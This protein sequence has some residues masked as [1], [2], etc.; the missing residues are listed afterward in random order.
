M[1]LNLIMNYHVPQ[2][3][4]KTKY[5]SPNV[6]QTCIK[7]MP[8]DKISKFHI[9]E[10]ASPE[11]Q[12]SG[13]AFDPCQVLMQASANSPWGNLFWYTYFTSAGKFWQVLSIFQYTNW[14]IYEEEPWLY[15]WGIIRSTRSRHLL[16]LIEHED[17][18]DWEHFPHYG[19][20]FKGTTHQSER[21]SFQLERA[22]LYHHRK[23]IGT[24]L[25][26]CG[27]FLSSP[28]AVCMMVSS[29]GNTL[30]VTCHLWGEC[31]GHRWIPLTKAS[32]TEL[33]CLLWFAP[34]Q[35]IEQ[36]METPVI[37]YAITHYDVTVIAWLFISSICQNNARICL[38]LLGLGNYGIFIEL[39]LLL[40]KLL[41][42][43]L[44]IWSYSTWIMMAVKSNKIIWWVLF[45]EII[46]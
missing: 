7:L 21:A 13:G 35:T 14:M 46:Y 8:H 6:H 16:N 37:W 5:E 15:A 30:H 40:S 17:E 45:N 26:L 2:T 38:M 10:T 31:T 34:E 25:A 23:C 39:L 24:V 1:P 28:S 42:V 27:M 29:K 36:T 22:P 12:A 43:E 9:P 41:N 20:L 32:D 44:L 11:C 19:A 18:V 4:C 33:W 3:I